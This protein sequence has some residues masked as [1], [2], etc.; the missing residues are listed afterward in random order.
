MA[1]VLDT[2]YERGFV[3]QVS[4]EEKLRERLERPISFYWGCDATAPS[5]TLG[6][7]MSIML[8]SWFQRFGH[9]PIVLAG[10][11]TTMIGD[12]SGRTSSRPILT[13]EQIAENLRGI[14]AQLQHF[15]DFDEGRAL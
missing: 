6:H 4:D 3:Q 1:N 11:G 9:R 14:Q 5:L 15:I 2:L 13:E 7:L 8:L 12:P 10:G